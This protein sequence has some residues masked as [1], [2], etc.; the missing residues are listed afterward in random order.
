MRSKVVERSGRRRLVV[1]ASVLSAGA[2]LGTGAASARPSVEI[3]R[4]AAPAPAVSAPAGLGSHPTVSGDGRFV[5]SQGRPADGTDARSS[6]VYLTDRANDVTREMTVVPQGARS[7]ESVNPVLSGDGC[8]LVVVTQLALDIFRDDDTGDR[9]DVYRLRLEHCG[10]TPGGWE[11]VSM[12]TDGSALARDDV[13]PHDTPA[14][15]RSGTLIAFTHPATQLIDAP[16]VTAVSLVD[17]TRPPSDPGYSVPV[18]GMPVTSPDTQF[19]HGGIDQPA[20]SGDGRFVAFRSDAGSDAAVPGWGTGSEPGGPAAKQIFVWDRAEPDPFLAVRL[21]SAR[22]DGQPTIAGASDPVLSRDGRVVAFT[23]ADLGLVPA[24]LPPCGEACPTQVFRL[25]RDTDGNGLYDEVS[26]TAMTMV[27]SV[28]LGERVVAG[29]APSSQPALSADGQLTAFVTKARNL[30]V[31]EAGGGGEPAD[32]DL[33][34]ADARFGTLRR[35]TV[36]DNGVRPSV[37]AHARPQL[38]DTG[39]TTVFDSLAAPQL[40]PGGTAGRQIVVISSEPT[41]SLAEADLGT[42]LVGYT[43]DE[44]YVAVINN[45]PTTFTPSTV[46]VSD[47]RFAVNQEASTCTLGAPV[48][49]GGDCTVR[50]TFTPSEPGPV[51]ATLTVAEEGFQAISVRTTVRG[52]GGDPTLRTNP[53]GADLGAAIVGQTS[54]EFLF[55]VQNIALAPTSVTRVVLAGAH[56][57]DFAISSTSC[58]E[59]ALNPRASCSVGVTFT[60]TV[61]GRRSALIQVFTPAGQYTSLVAAGDGRY[62]PILRLGGPDVE[63][64]R[65]FVAAGEGFPPDTALA[66]LFGDDPASSRSF[67]TGS[68][69]RFWVNVPVGP[70]QRGGARTVVAQAADGTVATAVVQVIEEQSVVLGLPGFG[71]GF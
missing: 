8:T 41:L 28:R 60:P 9:W 48:P 46:T 52:A 45:G 20:V 64:G 37:A 51:S 36:T 30:Q 19:V 32:G 61:A 40:V 57:G 21:V 63:A 7:G 6:T 13:S 50:L 38:S 18:A 42:T 59:R 71:Y 44:W 39:R 70:G 23:S 67:T 3:A 2:I 54:D 4:P 5:A 34:V 56:P 31:V 65:E 25:E 1:A 69:G 66:I 53:A 24:V 16:G 33:I 15:A 49:P 22:T 27:S 14:V 58:L 12:R 17:L 10:G 35:L 26:R 11:L 68:D 29:T 47:R 62:D 43:S 55:D